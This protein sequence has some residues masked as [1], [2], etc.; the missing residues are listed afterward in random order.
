MAERKWEK[1]VEEIKEKEVRHFCLMLIIMVIGIAIE[2]ATK[3]GTNIFCVLNYD[4]VSL[5]LIQVQATLFTLTIALVALLGG[6]IADEFLGVKYNNFILNIKP[7]YLTQKRII[8]LSMI[9][10]VANFFLHMF[11]YYN[12]VFAV[13]VVTAFLV[14]YSASLV[15]EAFVGAEHIDD[16]IGVFVDH[17]LLNEKTQV[18]VFNDFCEQ[19]LKKCTVQETGEY[20]K[21]LDVFNKG[22]S[23]LIKT[24]P[25]RKILL[26]RCIALSKLLLK[27]TD[28]AIRG[29]TFVNECYDNVWAFV[30]E[31]HFESS[32]NLSDQKVPFYLFENIYSELRG[33]IIN[34]KVKD[35]EKSFHWYDFT[36][37]ILQ[38]DLYLGNNFENPELN[39]EFDYL[40]EF[41]GLMGYYISPKCNGENA[42]ERSDEYWGGQLIQRYTYYSFLDNLQD[43]AEKIMANI[44]FCFMVSQIRYDNAV[45]VKEYCYIRAFSGYHKLHQPYIEML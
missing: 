30:R 33:A 24:D 23:E 41:G 8:S 17:A 37:H 10:L 25:N 18:N 44:Y 12:I 35:V 4:E 45:L 7:C 38:V 16:E 32:I 9:L 14:G 34:M 39:H 1:V 28:T 13:F 27:K 21:Y 2:I 36:K 22:F 15:Y 5:V 19:W 43:V 31:Y 26:D 20:E 3:S 29:I 42:A 40:Q 6:R 11:G